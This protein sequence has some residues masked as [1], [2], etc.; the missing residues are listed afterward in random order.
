MK[1]EDLD[2]KSTNHVGVYGVQAWVMVGSYKVSIVRSSMSY[3]GT[4][5][6]YE[7]GFF[8]PDTDDMVEVPGITNNDTVVGFLTETRVEELLENLRLI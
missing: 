5:G 1:F 8:D 2:F 3:G 4:R 7:M 6:L